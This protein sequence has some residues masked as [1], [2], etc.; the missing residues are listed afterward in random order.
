M[1]SVFFSSQTQSLTPQNISQTVETQPLSIIV[2]KD[3][4]FNGTLFSL[5]Y[6]SVGSDFPLI[7]CTTGSIGGYGDDQFMCFIENLV[8]NGFAVLDCNNSGYDGCPWKTYMVE[9]NNNL[10]ALFPMIFNESLFQNNYGFTINS[11]MVACVGFSGGGGALLSYLDEP[12]VKTVVAISPC[13]MEVTA[14]LSCPVLI[15]CGVNESTL[16]YKEHGYQFYNQ[17][18]SEKMLIVSD[19]PGGHS[20]LNG[21][22]YVVAWLRYQL[23]SDVDGKAY[24]MHVD[25]NLESYAYA[26]E[27]T[28]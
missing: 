5:I 23:R 15:S 7:I 12:R 22:S 11:S 21:V 27:D 10:E 19:D 24:L 17:I 25:S 4:M 3:L 1:S 14:G 16:P 6:P 28:S 20:V 9:A 8:N 13:Y 2:Q 18:E 26:N